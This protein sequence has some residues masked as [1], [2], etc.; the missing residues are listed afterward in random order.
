MLKVLNSTK[1]ESCGKEITVDNIKKGFLKPKV[2]GIRLSVFYGNRAKAIQKAE[3]S[4]GAKYICFMEH[5]PHG[6]RLFDL[7]EY[8]TVGDTE[9]IESYDNLKPDEIV[10]M[11]RAELIKAAQYHG[12]PGKLITMR[13]VDIINALTAKLLA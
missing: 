4:C 1:C 9:I 6:F 13:S 3:C 12:V 7:A 8:N 10:S 11:P 2:Y 5:G